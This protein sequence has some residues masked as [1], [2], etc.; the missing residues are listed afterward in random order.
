MRRQIRR[1]SV[2]RSSRTTPSLHADIGIAFNNF[3]SRSPESNHNFRAADD[4]TDYGFIPST[5]ELS[6]PSRSAASQQFPFTS[7]FLQ[8]YN[9]A[10]RT[11]TLR[12]PLQPKPLESG[13]IAAMPENRKD[14]LNTIV[15]SATLLS[16]DTIGHLTNKFDNFPPSVGQWRDHIV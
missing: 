8:R 4:S 10:P 3:N 1:A 11:I 12:M 7:D 2:Y 13:T 14:S 5:Y 9:R 6:L 15:P 16:T